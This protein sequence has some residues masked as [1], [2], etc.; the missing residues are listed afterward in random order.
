MFVQGHQ[1]SRLQVW[2]LTSMDS[3]MT[4]MTRQSGA[5]ETTAVKG[6]VISNTLES[7]S[8]LH[9]SGVQADVES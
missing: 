9:T 4:I 7:P 2:L 3:F 1:C 6:N 5:A 8:R